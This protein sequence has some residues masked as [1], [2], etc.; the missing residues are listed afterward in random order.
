LQDSDR[1]LAG[2]LA[3]RCLAFS[4]FCLFDEL[5]MDWQAHQKKGSVLVGFKGRRWR[6]VLLHGLQQLRHSGAAAFRKGSGLEHRVEEGGQS[7]V[8]LCQISVQ[9]ALDGHFGKRPFPIGRWWR[10]R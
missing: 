5:G 4:L 8:Q 10:Q 3:G 1:D 9:P 6:A 2:D 7:A